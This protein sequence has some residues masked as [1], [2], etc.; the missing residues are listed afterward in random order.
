[1]GMVLASST[2]MTRRLT[3]LHSTVPRLSCEAGPL[4]GLR[5]SAAGGGQGAEGCGEAAVH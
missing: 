4:A 2:P 3:I 5:K 1:M